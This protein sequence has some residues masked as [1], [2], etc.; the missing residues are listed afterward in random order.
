MA[1][2]VGRVFGQ[3][4]LEPGWNWN[5]WFYP[6]N[7]AFQSTSTVDWDTTTM[8]LIARP[9]VNDSWAIDGD[10][11]TVLLQADSSTPPKYR[12]AYVLNVRNA[13]TKEKQAFY[14]ATSE[15]KPV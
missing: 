5:F 6:H 12:H 7:G 9:W 14:I 2:I 15:L 1:T 3:F 11:M 8:H 4:T 13:D 10:E